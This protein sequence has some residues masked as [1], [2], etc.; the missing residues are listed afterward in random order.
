MGR[1]PGDVEILAAVKYLPAEALAALGDAGLRLLGENRAQ[2][3]I[4]KSD[5]YPG[6]FTWDFIGHLQS[7][8]VPLLSAA[9]PLHRVGRQRLGARATAPPRHRPHRG[10]RRGQR[11][12]GTRQERNRSGGATGVPRALPGTRRRVDDDAAARRGPRAEPAVFRRS[13]GSGA[14]A[15]ARAAVDGHQ[16]GLPGSGPR[17]ARRSCASA[18]SCTTTRHNHGRETAPAG[19]T[20]NRTWP[21]ETPGIE[22]LS[23]SDSRRTRR[24]RRN[25]RRTRRASPTLRRRGR[26]SGG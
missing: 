2:E 19:E 16:P 13:A 24:T 26:T 15:R 17:R 23:T 4:A 21:S 12:G 5:A 9:R 1:D 20:P 7:R 18:R 25:P 6:R 8:K 22:R 3:L 14:P 11:R 10:A